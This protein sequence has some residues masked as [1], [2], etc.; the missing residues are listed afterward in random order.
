LD[1]LAVRQQMAIDGRQ[2]QKIEEIK[3]NLK[4]NAMK[5]IEEWKE[6]N[7][8]K[9]NKGKY[10]YLRMKITYETLT[11]VTIIFNVSYF[12]VNTHHRRSSISHNAHTCVKQKFIFCYKH[13]IHR[14]CLLC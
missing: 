11:S 6:T 4:K 14:K 13:L 8:S 5:E 9:E 12:T 7:K 2:H 10:I 1:R 3:G